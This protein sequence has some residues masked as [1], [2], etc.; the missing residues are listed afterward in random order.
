MK[1]IVLGYNAEADA[2]ALRADN[3]RRYRFQPAVWR[4]RMSPS[5]GAPVD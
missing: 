2:I 3:V 4:E 1:V 5:K